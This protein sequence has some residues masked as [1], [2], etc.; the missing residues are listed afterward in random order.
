[1]L[2]TFFHAKKA[3][4]LF[5]GRDNEILFIDII[6]ICLLT[7]A[8]MVSEGKKIHLCLEIRL[9]TLSERPDELINIF[10]PFQKKFRYE[11]DRKWGA[12]L[13]R[14]PR[15]Q[16]AG[17]NDQNIPLTTT[18]GALPLGQAGQQYLNGL[19]RHQNGKELPALVRISSFNP[20][21]ENSWGRQKKA[22]A[23]KQQQQQQ[24][25][26]ETAAATTDAVGGGGK[27]AADGSPAAKVPANV[28]E[29]AAV[30]FQT[31]FHSGESNAFQR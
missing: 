11:F 5:C 1:M 23:R 2:L 13:R 24:Q 27:D 3:D 12:L 26:P 20:E 30:C 31:Q 7:Q 8:R 22:E 25:Q 9:Q 19:R 21:L 6:T 14:P 15:H 18:A 29:A 16:D 10:L 17:V 4:W 28:W